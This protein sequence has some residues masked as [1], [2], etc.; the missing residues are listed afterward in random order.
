MS[1]LGK[2]GPKK[3]KGGRPRGSYTG[4]LGTD[5]SLRRYWRLHRRRQREKKYREEE[6]VVPSLAEVVLG[7]KPKPTKKAKRKGR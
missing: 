1:D 5:T 6:L 4:S 7:K 3:G 2:R